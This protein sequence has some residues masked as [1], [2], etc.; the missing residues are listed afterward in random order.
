[1]GKD[2]DKDGKISFH[3]MKLCLAWRGG[4]WSLDLVPYS[5]RVM[6]PSVT[7]SARKRIELR[8]DVDPEGR[9]THATLIED[10]KDILPEELRSKILNEGI[11]EWNQVRIFR[12]G[13]TPPNEITGLT[14]L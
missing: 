12:N 5:E 8:L 2:Q 10:G 11:R 3:E 1:M 9:C 6:I 14:F 13:L 4:Q 7:T